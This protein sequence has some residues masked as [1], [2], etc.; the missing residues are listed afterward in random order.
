MREIAS[1]VAE[2]ENR[3]RASANESEVASLKLEI[4]RLSQ[5]VEALEASLQGSG[6]GNSQGNASGNASYPSQKTLGVEVTL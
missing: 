3:T 4:L 6:Q 5:K 2:V 1:R